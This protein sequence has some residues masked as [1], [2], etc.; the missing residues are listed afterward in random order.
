DSVRPDSVRPESLP[1]DD[2]S[3]PCR[4]RARSGE[5][6]PAFRRGRH[7]ALAVLARTEE[8]LSERS[9][10][11]QRRAFRLAAAGTRP[12]RPSSRR[13]RSQ[14]RPSK[15]IRASSRRVRPRLFQS[16]ARFWWRA[17]LR[18]AT[19]LRARCAPRARIFRRATNDWG[20]RGRKRRARRPRRSC[21]PVGGRCLPNPK[22]IR[23]M[24]EKPSRAGTKSANLAADRW[25]LALAC[26]ECADYSAWL[27]VARSSR[28]SRLAVSLRSPVTPVVKICFLNHRE[29]RGAQ[30]KSMLPQL[31]LRSS[32]GSFHVF[33]LAKVVRSAH[34]AQH[35]VGEEKLAVRRDHHDLQF[36]GEALGDNFVDQ[37]RILLQDRAFAGHALGVGRGG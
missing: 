12:W 5:I 24:E 27:I 21:G 6:L 19:R 3:R 1:D 36:V 8:L 35:I 31:L 16:L 32:I 29:H 33:R 9:A 11:R 14:S 2:R 26:V 10:S 37:Q 28:H 18:R 20:L 7:R 15:R 22:R 30:G 4:H 17:R 25:T 34:T 23:K 13:T